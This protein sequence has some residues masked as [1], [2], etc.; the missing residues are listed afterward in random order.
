M[1]TRMTTCSADRTDCYAGA[2]LGGASRISSILVFITPP[3]SPICAQNF[4][5]CLVPES[6]STV[7]MRCPGPRSNAV[8]SAATPVQDA[9]ALVH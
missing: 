9:L 2:P 5:K 8:R 6:Q 1:T 4:D 3:I 7:T